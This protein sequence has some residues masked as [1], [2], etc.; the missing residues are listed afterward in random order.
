MTSGQGVDIELLNHWKER[1]LEA[2]EN[3]RDLHTKLESA[4]EAAD[5]NERHA[6]ITQ[7]ELEDKLSDASNAI[8]A[9]RGEVSREILA[10]DASAAQRTTVE[11]VKMLKEALSTVERLDQ[12]L[13]IQGRDVYHV[14]DVEPGERVRIGSG[15]WATVRTTGRGYKPYELELDSGE[16]DRVDRDQFH[17]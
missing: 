1:A 12:W 3:E 14:V 15:A 5:S 11:A 9:T 4:R 13:D 8:R 7:R 6:R 17:R 16:T 10:G 2:E